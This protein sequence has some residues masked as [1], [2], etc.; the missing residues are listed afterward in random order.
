MNAAS[1]DTKR[2]V[3]I[4]EIPQKEYYTIQDCCI[5]LNVGGPSVY[6]AVKRGTLKATRVNG[7]LH[8]RHAALVAYINRRE[9]VQVAF[10]PSTVTIEEVIPD[11]DGTR[12]AVEMTPESAEGEIPLDFFAE[13]GEVT[14][15]IEEVKAAIA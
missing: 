10:D 5:I 3:W 12:A 11:I 2:N 9:Q 13:E 8:A 15:E 4:Q 7:K 14:D 1:Y 6:G